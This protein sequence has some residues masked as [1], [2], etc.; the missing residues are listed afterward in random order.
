MQYIAAFNRTMM[1]GMNVLAVVSKTIF[2]NEAKR[3]GRL[4]AAGEL[5]PTE[6]YT[7]TNAN[8]NT[9]SSGGSLYL[10]TVRPGD[11][12]W[13][14]G[15]LVE[16]K[17]D[18]SGWKSAPNRVAITDL[19]SLVRKLKFQSGKGLTAEPG[20]LGMSLQTPRALTDEDVALIQA[21]LAT[22]DE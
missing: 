6:R 10:V 15:I 18:D 20:K 5:W 19:T 9:L 21:L 3:D 8:L 4:L 14:V 16:P 11:Q 17:L 22:A 13:L 7:S 2:E 12:L 1:P